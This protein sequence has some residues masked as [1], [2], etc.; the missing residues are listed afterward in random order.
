MV[1]IQGLAFPLDTRNNNG[2]GI[3]STEI[4]NAISSLKS[5][6]IRVCPRNEPHVCDV[7]EDPNAEIGHIADVWQDKNNVY[8]VA[9]ITDSIA[10]RK[11]RDGTWKG[12]WSIYAG[13]DDKQ[14]GWLS[15]V[16]IKSLTLVNDPAWNDAKWT[17]AASNNESNEIRFFSSY[18]LVSSV[19]NTMTD[20][21]TEP[22]GGGGI[23]ADFELKLS[24]KDKLIETLNAE[25]ASMTEQINT[26][27]TEIGELKTVSASRVPMDEVQKMVDVQAQKI[28][29]SEVTKYKEELAK[30]VAL[31]KLTAARAKVGL[32]TDVKDYATLTASDVTKLSEDFGKITLSASQTPQYPARNSGSSGFT[33]GR[34]KSDG[35]WEV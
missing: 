2:E 35:T 34:P 19:G 5:A 10:D 22:T 25:K 8:A 4:E 31:E 20:P 11:I 29:A 12:G 13:G 23:P 16:N 33:V 30:G 18:Q 32:E 14:D 24:E 7:K 26:L 21:I 6:V 15:G 9:N 27:S 1:L 17:I 28:A 3:P